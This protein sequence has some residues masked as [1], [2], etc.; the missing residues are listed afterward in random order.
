M[1]RAR[2]TELCQIHDR[3]SFSLGAVKEKTSAG[4]MRYRR[5][6]D[7]R[8]VDLGRNPSRECR[9]RFACHE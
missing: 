7:R 4:S 9:R 6:C 8:N 5:S 1:G 3:L 2:C